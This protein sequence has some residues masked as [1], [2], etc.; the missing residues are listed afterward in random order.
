MGGEPGGA[1]AHPWAGVAQDL[2][3]GGVLKPPQTVEC[4]DGVNPAE[5]RRSGLGELPQR[6]DRFL[7]VPLDD[8]PLS[9]VT[10]PAV[11]LLQRRD[12]FGRRR[13][14]QRRAGGELHVLVPDPPQAS[15]VVPAAELDRLPQLFGNELRML[16][17][18]TIEVDHV[19]CSVGAGRQVDGPERGIGRGQELAVRL[20]AAGQKG[21]AAVV[22][23]ATLDQVR[24]RL[25]HESVAPIGIAQHIAPVNRRAAGGVEVRGR[26]AVVGRRR[27]ADREHTA[28]VGG[29]EDRGDRRRLGQVR[30]AA[31]HAL[32]DHGV[33]DRDRVPRREPPPPIVARQ[34][35]LAETGD[36]LDL[37]GVGT[38]TEVV[39][40]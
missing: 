28:A 26:L 39:P 13:L 7:I 21:R 36:D 12:Q 35:E 16:N 33:A 20:G 14:A 19:E 32:L 8:Q 9:G 10:A 17:H 23:H 34:A 29:V 15:S 6:G 24:Q 27:R 37:A 3:Q 4:P 38:E 40:P 1:L 31:E 30:V 18:L 25:A 22:Q 2:G 11:G 5:R